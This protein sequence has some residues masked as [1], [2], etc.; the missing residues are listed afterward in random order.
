[1]KEELNPQEKKQRA[2]DILRQRLTPY[3]RQQLWQIDKRLLTYFDDLASHSSATKGDQNDW[4]NYYELLGGIRFLRFMQTYD[5]DTR[6]VR[7]VIRLREGEW[8]QDGNRWRHMKGG[9]KMD[10][11]N[12]PTY[13]RWEPF[14]VFILASVFCFRE[15]VN[16]RVE[17]GARGL[18]PTEWEQDGYIYDS[19]RL[20]SDF[21][22]YGARKNDKTGLSAFM[23]LE[24]FLLEDANAEVYCIANSA[25]QAK[26]LYDRTRDMIKQ[27]DP[28][29]QKIRN[30]A[31]I[32]DWL[33]TYRSVHNSIIK[34]LTA[35]PKS[36]DGLKA[37][38]ASVDEYGSA[39]FTKGKSDM[40]K[41][42]GVVESSMALRREPMTFTTT[43]AGRIQN[44]PFM[45]K[46]TNLHHL[47]ERELESPDPSP[48]DKTMCLCLEPDQW[49]RDEET[50]LTSHA[51]RRK[52]CPMLGI[53]VQH[54]YYD[55]AVADIKAGIGDLDEYITKNMN[56]YK[57]ETS[58]EWISPEQ[59]RRLQVP[60]RISD[61]HYDQGWQEV[62]VGMDFS[63][64]DDLHAVSYLASR[65]NPQTRTREFFADCDSWM[66]EN[67]MMQSPMRSV[68]EKWVEQGWLHLSPGQTL[69]PTLPVNRIAEL[70]QSGVNM[71]MFL[72][73]P[74]KAKEPINLLSAYLYSIGIDPKVAVI[75]ARQNYASFNG[76][77][78]ELD[79]LIKNDPPLIRFSQNP[80]WPWQ[81]GNMVLDESTDGMQNHKPRKRVEGLHSFCKIDNF[82][83][84]LEGLMGYDLYQS[85][86]QEV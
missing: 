15:R 22:F 13:Y 53:V 47:L 81:A 24:F 46:L 17:A 18:L 83:C 40:Q 29:G 43:T 2:I 32:C 71:I 63:L 8:E 14:Q 9:L 84:I 4:H 64:G 35:G 69:Q 28:K 74:Y 85:K 68:F 59:V 79:Y 60:M 72:Y 52:V 77:V 45:E 33:P 1:M 51:L 44:G 73:D 62:F 58:Q 21:T 50:M 3:M 82:V 38:L 41:L 36:K 67:A 54:S 86:V 30:T 31:T 11:S 25:D 56:V 6:K 55:N 16:T 10:G 7:Q 80:L 19:R 65:I 37:S 76:P 34:P 66:T 12:G 48:T 57:A 5:L 23:Q 49:E 26:I 75:P 39:A 27:L 42:V 20:C 70:S 78:L 61:C